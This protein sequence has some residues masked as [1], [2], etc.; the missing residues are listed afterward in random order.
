MDHTNM[1]QLWLNALYSIETFGHD[2]ESRIGSCR[3]LLGF[4]TVLTH[5]INNVLLVPERRFSLSYACAEMLWYLSGQND[6]EMIKAYAPQYEKF[7]ENGIAYGAYGHRWGHN[8]GFVEERNKFVNELVMEGEGK[9]IQDVTDVFNNQLYSLVYLLRHNP[10]TR[11]AIMTMWDSGDLIHA[12]LEFH[13]DL[14]CTLSLCFFVRNRKLHLIATMRSNDAWLGLP[15]DVFC[16]TTLQRIIAFELD[17]ELGTYIHQAGSEH[18]YSKDQEKISRLPKLSVYPHVVGK[19]PDTPRLLSL[20]TNIERALVIEK[21]NRGMKGVYGDLM[22]LT[23]LNPI[24]SD[25]VL[26]C[27][28]KWVEVPSQWFNNPLYPLCQELC[29]KN[30]E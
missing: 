21:Q 13:K 30:N 2:L 24:F 3:E 6:I 16:F 15:Y 14:P 25:L 4:Q 12:I 11:Q 23:E 19:L 28:T 26:G 5:P 20:Q 9:A 1:D 7:A 8:P 10:N 27:A 18:I 29:R 22:A 17:L